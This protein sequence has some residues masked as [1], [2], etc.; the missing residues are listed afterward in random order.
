MHLVGI[1]APARGLAPHLPP[2]TNTSAD[3]PRKTG[4]DGGCM[5]TIQQMGKLRLIGVPQ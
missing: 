2:P 5:E 1:T 4:F 3:T